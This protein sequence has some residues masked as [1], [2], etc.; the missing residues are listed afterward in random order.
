LPLINV[1]RWRHPQ[2]PGTPKLLVRWTDGSGSAAAK[3]AA[4]AKASPSNAAKFYLI[5]R[6][7]GRLC[8]FPN[9]NIP[10][11]RAEARSLAAPDKAGVL[12]WQDLANLKYK[13]VYCYRVMS[14]SS[15]KSCSAWSAPGMCGEAI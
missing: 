1:H 8:H 13:E 15:D 2:G 14:C 12:E 11:H 10:Y 7:P 3:A 5:Q 6:C 4:A 9:N